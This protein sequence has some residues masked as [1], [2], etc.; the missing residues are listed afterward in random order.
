[1]SVLPLGGV[2]VWVIRYTDIWAVNPIPYERSADGKE[3]GEIPV[4]NLIPA[5]TGRITTELSVPVG[6]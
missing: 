4:R 5:S 6:D 1:M 3:Q 2:A